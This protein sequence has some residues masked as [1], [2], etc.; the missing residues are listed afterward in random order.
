MPWQKRKLCEF[1]A[2]AKLMCK[3][4]IHYL[5]GKTGFWDERK[6]ELFTAG[7]ADPVYR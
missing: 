5:L 3:M 4:N 7:T 6:T 2:A 1:T